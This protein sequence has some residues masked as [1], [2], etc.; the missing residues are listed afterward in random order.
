MKFI[1]DYTGY[2]QISTIFENNEYV[3]RFLNLNYN[4]IVLYKNYG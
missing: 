1:V 3:L 2:E 4:I